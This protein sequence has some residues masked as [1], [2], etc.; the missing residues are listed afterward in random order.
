MAFRNLGLVFPTTKLEVEDVSPRHTTK[1][2]KCA[3]LPTRR[4]LVAVIGS[5][6]SARTYVWCSRCAL[7]VL[8]WYGKLT[9]RAYHR[10]NP[11]TLDR[12]DYCVRIPHPH[13]AEMKAL[14]QAKADK[15]AARKA[16]KLALSHAPAEV[17]RLKALDD[18][19]RQIRGK[20]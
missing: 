16:A 11:S 19:H 10:L 6:R 5:Q 13:E 17:A 2:V 15:A 14:D 7:G 20:P 4:R 9:E 8:H 1:C 3:K 12:M 18:V